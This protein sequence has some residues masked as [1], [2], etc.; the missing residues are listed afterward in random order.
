MLRCFSL[1]IICN[2]TVVLLLNICKRTK[3]SKVGGLQF[4]RPVFDWESNDKLTELSQ[5][6]ADCKFCGK[7]HDKGQCPAY[8]KICNNCGRKNHFESKCQSASRSNSDRPRGSKTKSRKCGKCGHKK[9]D[10]IEYSQEESGESESD[11]ESKGMKDL[12]EQVQSLFYH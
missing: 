8:G 12:T 5:F 6:K 9:V 2:C 10:C 11:S 7:S 1:Y 4:S 3:M